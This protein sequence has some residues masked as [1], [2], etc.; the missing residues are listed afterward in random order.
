PAETVAPA[1][2]LLVQ[3][4]DRIAA[5]GRLLIGSCLVDESLISG[6]SAPVTTQAPTGTVSAGTLVAVGHA[7]VLVTAT[8]ARS[9]IGR[10]GQLLAGTVRPEPLLNRR[11][12]ALGRY[13]AW[14]ITAVAG[15]LV[16][17]GL[18]QGVPFW[19]LLR[20]AVALAIAAI[21]EGLPAVATLVLAIA[22]RRMVNA[23]VLVRRASAIETLGAVTTICLD[24]TGTLTANAMTARRVAVAGADLQVTGDGWTPAGRFL[25]AGAAIDPG[26]GQ[27]VTALITCGQWCNE[28]TLETD[29]HG[30]H[31]HGDPTEGALLV[32]AAKAGLPPD[33]PEA[34]RTEP[35]TSDHPWMLTLSGRDGGFTAC[36]KGAIE[37]V[38]ARCRTQLTADGPVPLTEADRQGWHATA[39]A[40]AGD[41]LRVLG[42]AQKQDTAPPDVGAWL[43]DWEGLG[44]VGLADPPRP[45]SA[46]M[47][48]RAHAAGIRTIMIT[49][50][51]PRTALAIA[52]ELDLAQGREPR[53]AV[54]TEVPDSDIDVYARARPA[55]K[56]ALVQALVAG[57]AVVAMTGDGVNDAPALQ[58]ASVGIAMGGGADVAKEAADLFLTDERLPTGLT[59]VGEGR[60]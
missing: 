32:L 30:W 51:H 21:P 14:T 20:T 39:E 40:M 24:K 4:G 54:G 5:D 43:D 7:T 3:A 53:V 29:E 49:G 31:I 11:L 13:L 44:L 16:V 9:A 25:R 36:I 57:G 46:A 23:G 37:P 26:P 15:L 8:G 45:E 34:L 1:D 18:V 50:D 48:A 28:A 22:A 60:A 10:V 6:E 56:L 33:R 35:A 12:D 59:A 42:L 52:R 27:P 58:A 47:L 41:A 38:L 2:I 17:L 55:G 19:P